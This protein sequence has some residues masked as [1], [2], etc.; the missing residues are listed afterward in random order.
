MTPA[1]ALIRDEIARTGPMPL[2]R[3]VAIATGHP[4]HGYYASAEP[5]GRG[6]D[7]VTAP[8]ISQ[9]FGEVIGLALGQAWLDQGAP[10]Q[11]VLAELGPGRGTLM[12]DILRALRIVPEAAAELNVHLVE[13]SA[14]LRAV[15]AETLA[16][17]APAWHDIVADLPDRPTYLV[18]NEFLD[19][20]PAHGLVRRDGGWSERA[21]GIDGAGDLALVAIPCPPALANA[22]PATWR[23]A[24]EGAIGEWA[25]L[26]IEAVTAIAERVA[27]QG[28]LALLIDYGAAAR[29][30]AGDTHQAVRGHRPWPLL[31][32]AGT[33]DLTSQ[34]DFA[35]LVAAAEAAGAAAFGPLPQGPFL[36]ALGAE[37]RF[38]T[39][40]HGRDPAAV[41]D[42]VRA[43]RRLL[44]PAAMGEAFKV[45]AIAPRSAP[46]PPGFPP[47]G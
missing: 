47:P 10:R 24:D 4:Q 1:E 45:L 16:G 5:F 38:D 18:A 36:Q 12:K 31:A 39:L 13:T 11:A 27:R 33:A 44:H 46:P 32:D 3:Y 14:R 21:V 19:A 8:E 30:P 2:Q 41:I 15:Q 20:L 23:D 42:L 26:R 25:P 6:G 35:P 7:F 28:G 40:A 37:A 17:V 34:V 43:R 29:G 9:V 22:L